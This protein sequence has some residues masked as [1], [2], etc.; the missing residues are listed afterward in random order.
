MSLI[1]TAVPDAATAAVRRCTQNVEATLVS[2][3][4]FTIVWF[5]GTVRA[6]AP[7]QSLP[8][9]YTNELACVVVNDTVGAPVAALFD[10][11]APGPDEFANATT[12]IA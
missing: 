9:A 3:I 6:T 4:W 7:V 12:V 8:A 2:T 1:V 10:A 11:E 5:A